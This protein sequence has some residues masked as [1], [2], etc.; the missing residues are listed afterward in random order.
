MNLH[1]AAYAELSRR[2]TAMSRTTA[3]RHALAGLAGTDATEH[4]W[5]HELLDLRATVIGTTYRRRQYELHLGVGDVTL[6][7]RFGVLATGVRAFSYGELVKSV[8]SGKFAPPV[9]QA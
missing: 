5:Q 8:R 1:S 4:F 3:R 9:V 2:I 6:C 7:R